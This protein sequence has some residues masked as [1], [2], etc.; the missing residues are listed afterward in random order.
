MR[1]FSFGLIF[2]LLL[3]STSLAFS[4]PLYEDQI[5]DSADDPLELQGIQFRSGYGDVPT[6]GGPGSVGSELR[7]DNKTRKGLLR[8][9]FIDEALK[10]W[11]DLKG[12]INSRVGLAFGFDYTSIY[13]IATESPGEDDSAGG[14]FRFFGAWTFFGRGSGNTSTFVYKVENR[15]DLGTQIAPQNLGFELGYIGLTAAP[16]NDA[17]WLLTNFYWQQRLL[18]GKLS[19]L[20]GIVDPTDYVDIY[21]LVNPW[22]QFSNLSFITSPTIPVPNQ[23]L[24]AVIGIMASDNIYIVAGLADTNGDPTDPLENF[25]TFFEDHEYFTHAEIGFVSSFDRRYLDNIHVTVWHADKREKFGIPDGWGVAFSSSW[26]FY[27]SI[28]PFF[29][30]GYSDTAASLLEANVSTGIGYY[31]KGSSDLVG[32]GLSWGEPHDNSLEDQYTTELFYRFQL[33]QNLAVTPDI[34]FLIDP[35]NNPEE[36]FIVVFGIRARLAL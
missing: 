26:Y 15:H 30:A 3:L 29:R 18:G 12:R 16:Y 23:G 6:F 25:D 4:Q 24:G 27:D 20:A 2:T 35:A 13:Q 34:Q 32:L 8:L 7:Q 19:I 17:G 9:K 5:E 28:L 31:M 21:A 14:I 36:D 22:T 33:A 11:F 1:L 10:P